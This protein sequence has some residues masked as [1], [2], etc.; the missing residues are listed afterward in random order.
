MNSSPE[1]IKT[2]RVR[3][4]L[5]F[6]PRWSF[7]ASGVMLALFAVVAF[8]VVTYAPWA[9][10]LNSQGATLIQ[11]YRNPGLSDAVITFTSVGNPLPT[12][13]LLALFIAILALKKRKEEETFII[14][15]FVA[16]EALI[17]TLKF[18]FANPRPLDT[19]IIPLPFSYSFPSAHAST[20][21]L[22]CAI[23]A[24][25]ALVGMKKRQWPPAAQ[26]AVL[27]LLILIALGMGLSRVYV[28]VHWCT[29]VLSGWALGFALS[30]PAV[31]VY[32]RAFTNKHIV[33]A[34]D[35]I[36][37]AADTIE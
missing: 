23:V 32:V 26:S 4:I 25:M 6:A 20:A 1:H 29:D 18:V 14:A 3:S 37:G 28:G 36:D 33:Q 31:A 10:E 22:L 35:A 15:F 34:H 19:N 7:V 21:V 12:I 24:M 16:S 5:S 9:V 11:S 2:Q 17:Q 30:I 8:G 13:A 27:A